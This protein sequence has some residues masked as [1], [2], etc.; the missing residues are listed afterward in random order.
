[1]DKKKVLKD[2]GHKE[3]EEPKKEFEIKFRTRRE[4]WRPKEVFE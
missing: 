3:D 2:V 4:R 1:M